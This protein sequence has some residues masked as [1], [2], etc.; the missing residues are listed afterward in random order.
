MN[1]KG[2]NSFTTINNTT[3]AYILSIYYRLRD[4]WVNFDM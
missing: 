2:Q 3:Y 1:E 4:S